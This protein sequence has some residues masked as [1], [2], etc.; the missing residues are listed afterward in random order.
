MNEWIFHVR[1]S[2][3][4]DAVNVTKLPPAIS[5]FEIRGVRLACVYSI[6][7][8]SSIFFHS[9]YLNWKECHKENH[10]NEAHK[11]TNWIVNA[12]RNERCQT[13]HTLIEAK[14]IVVCIA[15]SVC[16]QILDL[17][18][19]FRWNDNVCLSIFLSFANAH[20]RLQ[21]GMTRSGGVD[22]RV[23]RERKGHWRVNLF[24]ITSIWLQKQSHR[25]L[26]HIDWTIH[27]EI[28]RKD[29]HRAVS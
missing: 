1:S 14:A 27:P 9:F 21:I 26:I 7:I 19:V 3:I 8:F 13:V 16:V 6:S 10:Q 29:Y 18:H 12:N 28:H 20:Q 2:L 25:H 5:H 4:V 22:K 11:N 15:R 23:R 17:R 24:W